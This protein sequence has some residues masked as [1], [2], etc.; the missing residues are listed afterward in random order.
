[1]SLSWTEHS[2]WLGRDRL[3]LAETSRWAPQRLRASAEQ[4][5]GGGIGPAVGL[6]SLLGQPNRALFKPRVHLQLGSPWVRYGV[7]PWQD[8]LSR[9]QEWEQYARAMLRSQFG[10]PT[11]GWRLRVMA[12]GYGQPR[13]ACAMDEALHAELLDTVA[14]SGR[15]VGRI[16]PSLSRVLLRYRAHWP[17]SDFALLLAEDGLLTLAFFAEARWAGVL[18]LNR[19]ADLAGLLQQAASLLGL[20]VPQQV[21]LLGPAELRHSVLPQGQLHYLGDSQPRLAEREPLC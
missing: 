20:A 17:Q 6:A 21:Y 3:L 12:G 7:L 14:R 19:S 11:E 16:E 1:M 13:L 18:V 9:A 8:G 15:V 5:L 4:R 10:L 2:V